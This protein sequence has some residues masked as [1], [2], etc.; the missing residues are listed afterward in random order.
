[1]EN[2]EREQPK[3]TQEKPQNNFD[4]NAFKSLL[5]ALKARQEADIPFQD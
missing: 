2:T 5:K 1:M 4:V 3:D